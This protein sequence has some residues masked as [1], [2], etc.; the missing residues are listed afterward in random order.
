MIYDLF[1]VSNHFGGVGGGHYTAFAKNSL[2]NKWY[3]FNDSSCGETNTSRIVSD[4]A[5]NLFYRMRDDQ[6]PTNNLDYEKL[7]QEADP[8]FVKELLEHERAKQAAK[9]K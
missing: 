8:T 1:G 6:N 7:H 4:A 5:Y 2:N 3:S 9:K